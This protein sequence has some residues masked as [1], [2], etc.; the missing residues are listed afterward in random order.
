MYKNS[1][2]HHPV[3]ASLT[4]YDFLFPQNGVSTAV[5]LDLRP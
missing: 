5:S 2:A 1:T 3:I 4:L